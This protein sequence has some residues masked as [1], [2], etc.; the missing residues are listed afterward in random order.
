[1]KK[2]KVYICLKTLRMYGEKKTIVFTKGREYKQIDNRFNEL[3]LTDDRGVAHG[4]GKGANS[5]LMHFELKGKL[6][7]L[8][9]PQ[10]IKEVKR[11]EKQNKELL[12][13]SDDFNEELK[14]EEERL[15]ESDTKKRQAEFDVEKLKED[16]F[17]V[18]ATLNAR[19]EVIKLRD[20]RIVELHTENDRVYSKLQAY[21]KVH[22]DNQKTT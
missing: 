5:W 4:L 11:L 18:Q 6:E 1:M 8:T 14:I 20:E 7:T 21:R 22:L 13:L 15:K 3:S 19:N 16:C 10:L 2:G 17:N 9:K 12:Q